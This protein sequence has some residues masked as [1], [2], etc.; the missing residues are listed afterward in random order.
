MT[1]TAPVD[2]SVRDANKSCIPL[3]GAALCSPRVQ[4]LFL[5]EALK[6]T[7]SVREAE[8]LRRSLPQVVLIHNVAIW[9]VWEEPEGGGGQQGQ[10]GQGEAELQ[11]RRGSVWRHGSAGTGGPAPSVY[12]CGVQGIQSETHGKW[13]V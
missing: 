6:E 13:S 2:A 1:L 11:K 4:L 10:Q 9:K 8:W 5:L 7:H 12:T 3:I